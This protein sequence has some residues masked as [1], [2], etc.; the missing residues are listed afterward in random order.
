MLSARSRYH[1]FVPATHPIGRMRLPNFVSPIGSFTTSDRRILF[2]MGIIGFVAAYAASQMP[3]TLPFSRITLGL[4]EGQMSDVFAIVRASSLLGILFWMAADRIGRKRPI[5][6]GF[7]LLTAGSVLTAF[8][9]TTPLYILSQSLV[10]I[11]VVAIAGLGVLLIAE[12]LTPKIRGYGI[13]LYGL[14]GS[15]GVGTGLLLLPLAERADNAWRILFALAGLGLLAFPLL[16]RY[17]PESRAFRPAPRISFVKALGM[18]LNKHFWPLAG[19]S[20]F[21]AAYSAPAFDFALERL[22]NDLAWDTGAARFL[23]IVVSG[24]GV[25]G[26]LAGGRMAD[27]FGRRPTTVAALLLGLVGGLGF[28]LLDSGWFLAPAIFVATLGATMLTP[29][30]GAQRNELFP[31]RIRATAG[32]WITNVGILGGLFGFLVGGRLIDQI[33]LPRTVTILSAG[34]LISVAL[35]LT[36]PETKGMDLVRKKGGPA[37]ATAPTRRPGLRSEQRSTTTH[38]PTPNP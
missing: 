23:V 8:F 7:V 20:F 27:L 12:E 6:L 30:F 21:V 25:I 28:Y 4:T 18:G 10:R 5:L 9:P 19:I 17:L 33:G 26:L 22:I 13:G 35:V 24:V 37:G 31:T 14:S 2:L 15:L 29:S 36:L 32:G 3:H 11:A 38:P 16:S 34:L 1:P